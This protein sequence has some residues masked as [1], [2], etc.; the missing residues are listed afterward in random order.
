MEFEE[1]KQKYDILSAEI[2]KQ[3]IATSHVLKSIA[4]KKNRALSNNSYIGILCNLSVIVFL[5]FMSD[6][7]L[8]PFYIVLYIIVF[9]LVEVV[10]DTTH[11]F[12]L[13]KIDIQ[14]RNIAFVEKHIIGYRKSMVFEYVTMALMA[15]GLFIWIGFGYYDFIREHSRGWLM[16]FVLAFAITAFL[17]VYRWQLGLVKE[18]EKTVRDYKEFVK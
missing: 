13:K 10:W 15:L 5:L 2:E 17:F 4:T 16:V 8:V 12:R 1:L 11:I 18:W 3:G 14:N 7:L 9:L 6:K